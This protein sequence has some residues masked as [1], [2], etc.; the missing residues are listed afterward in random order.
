M[1]T[2]FS[3]KYELLD[4]L[5]EEFA[6]RFR[7]GERPALSEYLQ[8]YPE[9][10]A[11][12]RELFPAVVQVEKVEPAVKTPGTPLRQVGDYRILREIGRGGMGVVYEAEQAS[13]GRRVA[14]KVLPLH[15]GA[16]GKSLERFKREARAA[17]KLHHT[18]IVP[19]FEV[20]EDGEVCF[21]AMQFIQG[22]GLDQVIAE[23]RRL[24]SASDRK[25][26]LT[27]QGEPR[28]QDLPA[29]ELARSMLT[30]RFGTQ[31]LTAALIPEAPAKSCR[32]LEDRGS[33]P[34]AVTQGSAPGLT[35]SAVLPGQT[36]LSAA[37]ADHRHYFESI[38]RIGRQTASA[39]AHAH[40]RAI[41]HRDIKPSNLLLDGCGVVWVTD[42]GLAKTEDG[43]LTNPGDILGT[44]RYMAPERF[45]G[46][47]DPRSDVYALGITLY[48]LM[49]LRPAFEGCDR[50]TLISE[51]SNDEP[52]RP[53]TLDRRIPRDLETI[54]MKA[55]AKDPARRYQTSDAMAEDLRRF[56]DGE[57]IKA[58]RTSVVERTRLWCR[59]HKALAGLYLVL[60]L[61]AVGSSLSAVYLNHLLA[62]SEDNR[63]RT[64]LAEADGAEKLYESLVA[65]ANASR[66]SHQVG[67]R[68][69]TL[70]AV[71]KAADLVRER[72]MPAKRL[73]G[74]RNLAIAALALPDL[75]M[76]RS[77]P[78]FLPGEYDWD[79][80]DQ[81]RLYAR[82]RVPAGSIS[83]RRIET[84]EEIAV[85]DGNW[86]GFRFSPKGRF[87][88]ARADHR[89]RLWDV[90]RAK[91]Q[92][93]KEGE[94]YGFA[95][96]P[97]GRHLL[98]G[99][100]DGGLWAY[101]LDASSHEPSLLVTL[102]PPASAWAFDPAGNRLALF[103]AGKAEIRDAK[104]GKVWAAIP[105]EHKVEF[106]AWHPS[107][108]YLALVC[109]E[110]EAEIRIWDIKR[111]TRMA[112]LKGS[113]GAG[114]RVAFTPEGDRLL[115]GGYAGM[116]RLWD[117]RTGRQVLQ[118]PGGSNLT[119]GPDGQLLIL[120][121]DGQRFRLVE[122]AN[123]REYRSF[124][125][126]SAVG[127]QI[128]YHIPIIHPE[129]RLLALAMSDRTRLFDLETGD[130]L[131]GLPKAGNTHAFQADGAL[132]N[133]SVRGL[134]RWPIYK[135]DRGRW[136]IGPPETVYPES[137]VDIAADRNGDVIGQ[138]TGNG[139]LLVRRGKP[140]VL[141][142]PHGGGQHIAIS[143][144]GNYAA[145]GVNDG[146]QGVK[147]WDTK[148]GRLLVHFPMGRQCGGLFSPDGQWLALR[149]SR[150]C[151][152]VKVGTWEQAFENNWDNAAFSPDG[153]VLAAGSRKGAI[154]L[155]ETATGR[156]LAQVEDP[157]QTSGDGVFTPDGTK[158]VISSN[159]KA[160][161]VWDLRRIRTQ[162]AQ[163]E[164]DWDQP[165][166]PP[167]A[168]HHA[169]A[170][171]AIDVRLGNIG[172]PR[173]PPDG[174]PRLRAS[175]ALYTL[176]AR[177]FPYHPEP[178]HQRAHVYEA[179]G[180]HQNAID[181]FTAALRWQTVALKRRA[182]L[183]QFRAMSSQ[184]IHREADAAADLG[185]AIALDGTNPVLFNNLAQIY[186][187]GPTELR[188]PG[189][190]LALA[191]SGLRL[192]ADNWACR[193]TLG[194]AHY[195]LNHFEQAVVALERS[196][197][198]S[199]GER[200]AYQLYF[201]AMCYFRLGDAAKARDS[202]DQAARWVPEHAERLPPGWRERL[203]T[204]RGEADS[205]LATKGRS[206]PAQ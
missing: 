119:F 158:L 20:G 43:D 140:T 51:I 143:P 121:A 167:A 68:F 115:S 150:G 9:L 98:V 128:S 24:R 46:H 86:G 85:L 48:E 75:Q 52:P 139:A 204:I 33:L 97:D 73:D 190:A 183:Y 156:E 184:A 149:G 65:Q 37:E 60:F 117:W 152:V 35:S 32:S 179:L 174:L 173:I 124:V 79:A 1:N 61:A 164:L 67:Q 83:V 53:R 188:A 50:A 101:D 8:R 78:G 94:E 47:S 7:K 138:T 129:G 55:I 96:H 29:E 76:L 113:L 80:D 148:T 189:K 34:S 40:E 114:T 155:L 157:N 90:S 41:I 28:T 163:M 6:D 194:V 206:A 144:N 81:F 172:S 168:D 27:V 126:Q 2:Q 3:G 165:P 108:N 118:Q 103:R 72:H 102:Q 15:L 13:L 38:A 176:Q 31:D 180:Q 133:N 10:A 169:P 151:R 93:V 54:V 131:A 187:N 58:R 64:A 49:V 39:L 161:H 166:Y 70:E 63:R 125:Q 91:P 109:C 199:N 116:L 42:F 160:V 154:R 30:G 69:A 22:Q 95:F 44:F 106:A 112:P 200:A 202:Y 201:L 135:T 122:V 137:F 88:L 191:E 192:A 92:V 147:L 87:L 59:R 5:V 36:Q 195:R 77:W 171:L 132:L 178:Y 26:Q 21:Y 159:D 182:H 84:D 123:G 110:P 198:E 181:D 196:L 12:I 66:F 145:T 62:E 17:A 105:E 14:L 100:R 130:E 134:L 16:D 107:G 19:V 197:R 11:E 104:T 25:K 177:W 56:L 23:L 185:K 74:L 205:V 193:N 99:R 111:V 18:N 142:S 153:A 89:F 170:P 71:G 45:K 4:Q 141:L 175:L 162:L 203:E 136:Q 127:K 82:Q 120:D 146:E 186:V 57:P